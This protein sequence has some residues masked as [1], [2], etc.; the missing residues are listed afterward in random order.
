MDAIDPQLEEPLTLPPPR[1]PVPWARTLGC[2]LLGGGLLVVLHHEGTFLRNEWLPLLLWCLPPVLLAGAVWSARG[3]PAEVSLPRWFPHLILGICCLLFVFS[4]ASSHRWFYFLEWGPGSSARGPL[5]FLLYRFLLFAAL[6]IP[7][8]MTG[9]RRVGILLGL[10][11]L[12]LQF[13]AFR[14]LMEQTAGDCLYRTDHPSFMFRLFEFSH[15]FPQLV[16]YNPHWNA[17]SLHYY[18]V[19]TG[20]SGPGLLLMPFLKQFPVHEIYTPGVGALFI[21]LVPWMAVGSVRA[22]GGNGAA[23]AVAGL[24]ALG[25]SQHVFLWMLHYGTIGAAL[26]SAMILP[27]SALTFRAVRLDRTT[28]W[29]GAGIVLTS[30]FLLLWPPGAVMG[31]AV[32]LAWLVNVRA[33][34]RK[35][36]VFLGVCGLIVALLYLKWLLVLMQEGRSVVQYVLQDG[37][38]PASGRSFLAWATRENLVA[39]AIHLVDHFREAHPVLLFFGLVGTLCC[40][41]G[42]LRAWYLPIILFLLVLAGWGPFMKPEFQLSRMIIPALFVAVAPASVLVG[43]LLVQRDMRL[44]AVRAVLVALLGV[45]AYSVTLVYENRGNAPYV[46][47]GDQVNR[48]VEWIRS[49][50]PEDTRVMFM[51]KTVHAYGRGQIAYLPVLA[52]REMMACDYYNFPPAAVE[53]EYPPGIFKKPAERFD[54]F[55]YAYNI[56]CA[57]TYHQRW[58]DYCASRPDVF[59]VAYEDDYITAYTILREPTPIHGASGTVRAEFNR[60]HVELDEAVE[61]CML[62]Y[63]WVEGLRSGDGVVIYPREP[64]DDITLIGVR[65]HGRTRFTLTFRR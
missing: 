61:E 51:G 49:E 12:G 26:T 43:R 21:V 2:L 40:A 45:G 19:T 33:W 4:S 6:L 18:S 30:F 8:F 48:L 50:V 27:V 22:L 25:V 46:T 37:G 42:A 56:G 34:S 31:L 60:L 57:I 65:P 5:D 54:A 58:K 29:V 17:G 63:N 36:W 28:P 13:E 39:G 41:V 9:F 20:A 64:A 3:R 23:S 15:T 14:H 7:L 32:A 47:R 11:L 1:G 53:Y 59:E 52:E 55:V 44:A 62:P 10:I 35:K 16:N 38:D 24:L